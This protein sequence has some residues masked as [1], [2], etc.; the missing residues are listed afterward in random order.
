MKTVEDLIAILQTLPPKSRVIVG[1]EYEGTIRE[2]AGLEVSDAKSY[3]RYEKNDS[4]IVELLVEK[5]DESWDSWIEEFGEDPRKNRKPRNI[6]PKVEKIPSEIGF[7]TNEKTP[8]EVKEI[9]EL[10]YQKGYVIIGAEVNGEFDER[11]YLKGT[12]QIKVKYMY[13]LHDGGFLLEP[14]YRWLITV[15]GNH[16][17]VWI[18]HDIV[19]SHLTRVV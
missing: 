8:A 17:S 19:M 12:R 18:P 15:P 13:E 3:K 6:K 7:Y 11:T 2:V 16:G 14:Y 9:Y 5:M 10:M 4:P 1:D